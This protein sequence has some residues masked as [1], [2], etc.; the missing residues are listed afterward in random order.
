MQAILALVNQTLQR[1]CRQWST[2]FLRAAAVAL[3]L[4]ALMV[5]NAMPGTATGLG[6]AGWLLW[7]D[8]FGITLAAFSWFAAAICEEREQRTLGLLR[9]TG[10][11]SLSLMLGKWL[12][13]MIVVQ[14]LLIIQIPL[15]VLAV[16]MGG[17]T[18]YQ[19]LAAYVALSSYTVMMSAVGLFWSAACAHSRRASWWVAAFWLFH[20]VGPPCVK[21]F[22]P[23]GVF[24]GIIPVPE[25]LAGPLT[26]IVYRLHTMS[27]WRR[28]NSILATGFG[29]PIIET[30]VVSNLLI[31]AVAFV[32]AWFVIARLTL[33][34]VEAPV[35]PPFRASKALGLGRRFARVRRRSGHIGRCWAWPM[36]WREFH[37]VAGGWTL[38]TSKFFFYPAIA[39]GVMAIASSGSMSFR[40]VWAQMAGPL[41][42]TIGMAGM[43]LETAGFGGKLFGA[44][45]HTGT[46]QELMTLPLSI[47]K[48]GYTKLAGV[49]ITLTP[50]ATMFMVGMKLAPDAASEFR[51]TLFSGDGLLLTVF[52]LFF[53]HLGTLLSVHFRVGGVLL[54]FLGCWLILPLTQAVRHFMFGGRWDT[55]LRGT[56]VLL[57]IIAVAVMHYRIGRDVMRKGQT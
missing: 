40:Q 46:I 43:L 53:V 50:A 22:L 17:V 20:V 4:V 51:S 12:P 48:I 1:D 39:L 7:L 5:A 16:T 56:M 54:A 19:I 35:K 26:T 23:R 8:Y 45:V 44:E 37:F 30:Q 47:A 2:G 34:K 27:L 28:L 14:V 9:M 32:L 41:F 13:R 18:N 24:G 11:N 15:A 36:A 38:V 49:A 42:M 21:M 10:V 33:Y 31:G 25:P 3:L 52:Y 57:G 29:E 6:F 55:G